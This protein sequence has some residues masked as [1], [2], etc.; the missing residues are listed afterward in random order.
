MSEYGPAAARFERPILIAAVLLLAFALAA[1]EALRREETRETRKIAASALEAAAAA[2]SEAR[3]ALAA[4]IAPDTLSRASASVYLVLVNGTP[5]G[6]AFVVDRD[7]GLLATAAHT[8]E[9][10]PL[11]RPGDSVV[12]LNRAT[13]TPIPV[14]G[15]KI[16]GG[17]GAFRAVIEA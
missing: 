4:I 16:H 13:R 10:L 1:T 17:Y 12:I 2:R 15:R 11:G 6:T 3:A 7:K 8:A 9:S 14:V 5:R